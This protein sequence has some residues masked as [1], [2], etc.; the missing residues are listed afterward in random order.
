MALH[1]V[2][3]NVMICPM[4]ECSWILMIYTLS[5]FSPSL[6]RGASI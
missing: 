2:E 1:N 4:E 6:D 5:T 3:L